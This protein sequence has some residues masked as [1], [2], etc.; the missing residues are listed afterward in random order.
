MEFE[1]RVTV[2]KYARVS[3]MSVFLIFVEYKIT[4]L[5]RFFFNNKKLTVYVLFSL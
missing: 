2:A 1:K 5:H 4:R 3:E